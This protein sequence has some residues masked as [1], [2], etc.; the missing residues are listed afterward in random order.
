MI[1]W[2]LPVLALAAAPKNETALWEKACDRGRAEACGNLGVAYARAGDLPRAVSFYSL[3]CDLGDAERCLRGGVLALRGTKPEA[4]EAA[5]LFAKGCRQGQALSCG[6][7]HFLSS[8]KRLEEDGF[9]SDL[10][11]A[12]AEISADDLAAMRPALEK[13]CTKKDATGCYYLGV[14]AAAGEYGATDV[15]RAL[16]AYEQACAGKEG[17]A[18]VA[19]AHLTVKSLGLKEGRE[20]ALRFLFDGCRLKAEGACLEHARLKALPAN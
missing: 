12:R 7:L 15:G 20:N 8:G 14:F 16:K 19:G 11:G 18:C 17:A 4:K 2:L 5:R 10:P 1:A 6:N 3:A 9:L 13:A